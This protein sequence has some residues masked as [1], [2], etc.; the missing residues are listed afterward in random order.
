M[1]AYT[2]QLSQQSATAFPVSANLPPVAPRPKT[3]T[4]N[5]VRAVKVEK[6][7]PPRPTNEANSP[8]KAKKTQKAQHKSQVVNVDHGKTPKLESLAEQN[9]AL[10]QKIL[11]YTN[12][13]AE[14]SKQNAKLAQEKLLLAKKAAVVLGYRK[15]G[16]T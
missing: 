7:D 13:N 3:A 9:R 2:P 1:F 4:P 16:A 10:K 6:F 12:S 15:N 11:E 14:L 8:P 5:P